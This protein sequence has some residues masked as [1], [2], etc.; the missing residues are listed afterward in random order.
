[1][2]GLEGIKK[3]NFEKKLMNE[4]Y[5]EKILFNKVKYCNS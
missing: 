1:M 4:K 3:I 2:K 5:R